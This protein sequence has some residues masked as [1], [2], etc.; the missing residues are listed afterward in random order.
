[1]DSALKSSDARCVAVKVPFCSL[2]LVHGAAFISAGVAGP[3]E[4]L[5]RVNASDAS[6]QLAQHAPHAAA[7]QPLD[8]G[9]VKHE[10][11][12]RGGREE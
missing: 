4:Q 10:G 3:A 1:M 12:N 9:D 11:G 2:R 7:A 5:L 6:E 8:R